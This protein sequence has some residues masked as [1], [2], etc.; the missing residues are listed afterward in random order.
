MTRARDKAGLA[1]QAAGDAVETAVLDGLLRQRDVDAAD[2]A[3]A[4]LR[5]AEM[6]GIGVPGGNRS[7]SCETLRQQLNGRL[8][9]NFATVLRVMR[10]LGIRLRADAG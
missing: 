4:L 10:A 2:V 1:G 5:V 7:L 8:T 9:L 3:R 6:R